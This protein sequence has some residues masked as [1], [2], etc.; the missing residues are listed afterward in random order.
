MVLDEKTR[1]LSRTD[2]QILPSYQIVG[3]LSTAVAYG[4]IL[5]TLF[6][7]T[8]P[9]ECQSIADDSKSSSLA[10]SVLVATAGLTQLI[11]PVTGRISDEFGNGDRPQRLPYFVVGALLAL[12]GLLGQGTASGLS[13]LRENK[14]RLLYFVSF[15]FLM[16]GLNIMY[17]VMLAL[18]ADQVPS[19]QR[20][21]ANGILAFLL[22]S[23]SLS[24]LCILR[25]L[26][27]TQIDRIYSLYAVMVIGSSL[28]TL[29]QA[30]EQDMKGARDAG[31]SWFD[32]ICRMGQPIRNLRSTALWKMYTLRLDE[33]APNKA[34]L[35]DKLHDF[36]CIT[37]SR[38]FY[39]CGSSAQTFFLY[40]LQDRLII[41]KHTD[42]ENV[43]ASLAILSQLGGA[44]VCYPVGWWSDKSPH[45][46][47]LGVWVA[48]ALFA[49]GTTS[50]CFVTSIQGMRYVC[51]GLGVAN[52]MYLT[53]ETRL[54]V[55]TL[56]EGHK[57][58]WMGI[59]GVAAFL[60]SAMG[61]LVGGPILYLSS[62]LSRSYQDVQYTEVGY[63]IVWSLSSFY[64]M[65]SAVS[66][67]YLRPRSID[68]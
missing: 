17:S 24:G 11:G 33:N 26:D 9:M 12:L 2:E 57:A 35:Q 46:Q 36:S 54:A 34:E 56:P 55:D 47:R 49:I 18:L 53:L 3:L 60:G 37:V 44:L 14:G 59:W 62:D 63:S 10:L 41:V 16:L 31:E 58:Q 30:Y 20:G 32:F 13:L 42:P 39:Y 48:C 52:G 61:P 28:Y 45:R 38:L 21:R 1:L 67:W 7:L 43:V 29:T 6:L 50:L 4:C 19:V 8:L 66:L 51:V 65:C 23:G 25:V 15:T 22:V 64:F 27:A 68:T 5:S 40:F